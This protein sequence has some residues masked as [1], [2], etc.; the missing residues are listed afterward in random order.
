MTEAQPCE[1]GLVLMGVEAI[2]FPIYEI[3]LI[4]GRARG[5]PG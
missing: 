1:S 5:G 2:V 4:S 3:E